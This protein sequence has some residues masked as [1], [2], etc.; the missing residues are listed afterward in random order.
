M[1]GC[2]I[3]AEIVRPSELGPAE[4]DEWSQ[5]QLKSPEL[6]RA[7]LSPTFALACERAYGRAYVAV[8][9]DDI[10]DVHGFL[11]FQFR[12]AW[13]EGLRLAERIGGGMSDAAGVI[14]APGISISA[15]ILLR[16][17]RLSSLDIS[18]IVPGQERLGLDADWSQIDYLTELQDGPDAFFATLLQRERALVR[19][20]ERQS[21]RA[22]SSL[23]PLRLTRTR[24][25]NVSRH[26][27][28]ELVVQKR[29]QYLRTGVPDPL[30]S[31]TNRRLIEAMAEMPAPDCDLA[32]ER[33]FSGER[34]VAQHLGVQYR[35]VLSYWFPAYDHTFHNLSPGRLLLWHTIRQAPEAGITLIDYGAGDAEY[36]R[37]LATT[38]MK[39]GRA[40]WSR[41]GV[42]ALA[43]RVYQAIE[44]RM[45]MWRRG[46]Y[47]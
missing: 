14:A 34:L 25:G 5:I 45:R 29:Q 1:T 40:S 16:L 46:A 28:A 44:W 4:L 11:P 33:L 3:H 31:P 13:H 43:A 47:P 12:S 2:D 8:L 10:G 9:I 38:S 20:T 27:V 24:S 30:A 18:H 7:F 23:G 36:K 42:R 35:D 26:M 37:R 19:D 41:A 15:P 17:A 21:R 6:Q 32:M 39:M 22:E